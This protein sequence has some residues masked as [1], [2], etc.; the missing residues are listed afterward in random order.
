MYLLS[1]IRLPFADSLIHMLDKLRDR[2]TNYLSQHQVC[3]LSIARGEGAWA[4]PVHYRSRGLEVDCLV[5]RWADVAYHLEQDPRVILVIRDT[6]APTLR[7]LQILGDVQ[8]IEQPD[9]TGLLPGKMTAP[10]PNDLYLVV[11]VTPKR[12]DLIDESQGWG[13]RETLDL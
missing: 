13:A 9:W 11:R 2:I 10:A 8:I 3:V 12:I 1:P 6:R 4:M 5:P 7:W